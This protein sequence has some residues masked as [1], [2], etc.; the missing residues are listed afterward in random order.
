[1]LA[2][3]LEADLLAI[4][5]DARGVFV[6]W[7]TPAARL[8]SQAHPDALAAL[9]F[10]AGSMGPKVEAACA[11]ARQSAGTAVIGALQE[12]PAILAGTGGTRISAAFAGIQYAPSE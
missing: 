3:D 12:L 10:P 5:T 7:G 6:D 4:V 11:F 2:R 8:V 1:M 9:P